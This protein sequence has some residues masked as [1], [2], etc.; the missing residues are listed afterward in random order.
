MVF[1]S[2]AS[3]GGVSLNDV[4]LTG[5]YLTNSLLGVLMRFIKEQV[6]STADIEYLVQCF[7]VKG[8]L[9]FLWYRNNYLIFDAINY[10]M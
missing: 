3:C 2:R 1:D 10:R 5:P 6:A 9:C 7:V 4:L 8:F